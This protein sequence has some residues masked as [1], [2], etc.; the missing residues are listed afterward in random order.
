MKRVFSVSTRIAR[1]V[2]QAVHPILS[3]V[4]AQMVG[5]NGK[6]PMGERLTKCIARSDGDLGA[7]IGVRSAASGAWS[8]RDFILTIP[9]PS[10]GIDRA[11]LFCECA[12]IEPARV[13]WR[14]LA[15]SLRYAAIISLS[16]LSSSHTSS[17]LFTLM[18]PLSACG[19]SAILPSA[20]KRDR[21]HASEGVEHAEH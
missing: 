13:R 5:R 20:L 2:R 15:V 1:L 8:W 3:W 16:S 10:A 7:S 14:G 19:R 21:I 4:V 18:P 12:G 9:V 6:T 17:F 11:R